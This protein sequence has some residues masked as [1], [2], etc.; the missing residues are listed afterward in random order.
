MYSERPK[1][2]AKNIA[3][4]L[5][6]ELNNPASRVET[7]KQDDIAI[8]HTLIMTTQREMLVKLMISHDFQLTN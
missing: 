2:Q 1:A 4:F 7:P 6:I 8:L 5:L 3:A